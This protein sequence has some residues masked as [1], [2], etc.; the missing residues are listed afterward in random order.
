MT[1]PPVLTPF[2]APDTRPAANGAKPQIVMMND[3]Q[4]VSITPEMAREWLD[5]HDHVVQQNEIAGERR[6]VD[7]WQG[8]HAIGHGHYWPDRV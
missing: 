4:P 7:S 2:V 3:G 8:V 1:S 5:R 6:P